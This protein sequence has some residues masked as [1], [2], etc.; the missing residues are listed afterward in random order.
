LKLNN[1]AINFIGWI[2][3]LLSAT[4]FMVSALRS[5]DLA[6]LFGAILFF[7]ACLVFLIPFF[8]RTED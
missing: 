1:K 4:G 5:G 8:R 7:V 6:A 3:F 2:L